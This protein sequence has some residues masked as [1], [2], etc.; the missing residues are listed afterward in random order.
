MEGGTSKSTESPY[1]SVRELWAME[2]RLVA[3]Q[4]TTANSLGA[5]LLGVET[6]LTRVLKDS[7]AE[8]DA[9]HHQMDEHA[10]R[11]HAAIDEFIDSYHKHEEQ[12][13]IEAAQR[14][15]TWR[16]FTGGWKA[17]TVLDD[18]WRII[19]LVFFGILAALGNFH[20]SIQ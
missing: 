6:R 12:E 4:N 5:Q 3:G 7:D 14:A 18:H 11:R 19:F 9:T 2:Q 13:S 8:H 1:A 15:G 20:I 17:L 16:V 10:L